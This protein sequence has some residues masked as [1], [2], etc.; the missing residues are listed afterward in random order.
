MDNKNDIRQL[1]QLSDAIAITLDA[2]RRIAPAA[3]N[4]A[5]RSDMGW[6]PAPGFGAA[7]GTRLEHSAWPGMEARFE[8]SA[9][10]APMAGGWPSPWPNAAWPMT[11]F[12]GPRRPF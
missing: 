9:W 10:P 7:A 4:G 12:W 6:N 1:Q 11:G 8:H 5:A 2:I 3:W